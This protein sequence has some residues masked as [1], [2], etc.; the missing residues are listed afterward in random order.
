MLPES[1]WQGKEHN[2]VFSNDQRKLVH[3]EPKRA[4]LLV[5]RVPLVEA[6]YNMQYILFQS[7]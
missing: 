5:Q 4:D 7:V 6:V 3:L 2:V 1:G